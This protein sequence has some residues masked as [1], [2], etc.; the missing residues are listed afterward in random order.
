[1]DSIN[2]ALDALQDKG[3]ATENLM[4]YIMDTIILYPTVGEI[5]SVFKEAIGEFK[6]PDKL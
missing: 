2:T 3:K 5:T 1:M 6:E 4:P